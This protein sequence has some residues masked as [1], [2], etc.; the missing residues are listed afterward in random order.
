M[1]TDEEETAEGCCVFE[2]QSIDYEFTDIQVCSILDSKEIK[3]QITDMID[4]M[5]EEADLDADEDD[6]SVHFI[7][8]GSCIT[9]FRS[10]LESY[11]ATELDEFDDD[12]SSGYVAVGAAF[13]AGILADNRDIVFENRSAYQIVGE[14]DNGTVY[15]NR[16]ALYGNKTIKKPLFLSHDGSRTYMRF[17]QRFDNESRKIY[18]GYL[19][20][21]D[22]KYENAVLF[23][24]MILPDG[25]IEAEIY[26][27]E[28][29][30]VGKEIIISEEL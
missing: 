4:D 1:Y 13:Y 16:N 3:T 23:D 19:D 9:Y 15:L 29:E 12:E 24:L 18:L 28:N 14:L 7:G 5:L 10:L 11:F 6:I 20:L 26:G 22:S 8:G 25:R 27:Q 17:Y 30:S 2:G 21:S